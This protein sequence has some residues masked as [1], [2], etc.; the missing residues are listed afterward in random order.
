MDERRRLVLRLRAASGCDGTR[1]EPLVAPPDDWGGRAAVEWAARIGRGDRFD[2]AA[3]GLVAVA[4]GRRPDLRTAPVKVLMTADAVGGVWT[5]SLELADA[6]SARGVEVSLAVMGGAPSAGQRTELARVAASRSARVRP[7]ALEWMEDPWQDVERAGDVAAPLAERLEPDI[8]HL[9]GYVHAASPWAAPVL[10]VAHSCVLSW[11]EAVRGR[12]RR[13]TSGTATACDVARGPRGGGPAG[14]RADARDARRARAAITGPA[15]ADASWSRTAAPRRPAGATSSG[16]RPRRWAALGRGEEHRGARAGR[17]AARVAGRTSPAPGP[18]GGSV[19][20]LRQLDRR[21]LDRALARRRR[22]SRRP[23]ATSRSGSPPSRPALRRLRARARRHPEPARGLGRRG[24]LRRRRTTTARSRRRS[25]RS[26]DDAGASARARAA[27]AAARRVLHGR[28]DGRRRTSTPTTA[29]SPRH[30]RGGGADEV[31]LLLPLAGL[32]LEPRQRAFPAR[33]RH[34]SCSRAGT[35]C[36]SSSRRTAGAATNL[37]AR[38][39]RARRSTS[40]RRAFPELA[41]SALRPG[42]ARPRRGARRRRRS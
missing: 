28:A 26:I 19:R 12:R 17:A 3:E 34:A 5:Y 30:R 31:R 36:G 20:A 24:A 37:V 22:S 21:A 16:V 42:D 4:R 40:S 8:V 27:R 15:C 7:F 41:S 1:R 38:A 2:P 9:N 32:R 13:R 23:R 18:D 6:L 35:T 29:A 10:V 39:R 14:R 11:C 25:A 33:R